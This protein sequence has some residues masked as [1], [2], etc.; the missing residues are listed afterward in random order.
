MVEALR[1]GSTTV[2][3]LFKMTHGFKNKKELVDGIGYCQ[4]LFCNLNWSIRPSSFLVIST[5]A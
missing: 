3:D 1:Q 2:A 4:T 5:R